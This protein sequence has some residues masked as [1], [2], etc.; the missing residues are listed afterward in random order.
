MFLRFDTTVVNPFGLENLPNNCHAVLDIE[1]M[2]IDM[3]IGMLGG[4]GFIVRREF[5]SLLV[6]IAADVDLPP[7]VLV[8]I[9]VLDASKIEYLAMVVVGQSPSWLEVVSS[10]Q[11]NDIGFGHVNQV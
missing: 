4:L 5:D 1:S 3:L 2:E 9:H 7:V 8:L 10:E 11:P 6:E